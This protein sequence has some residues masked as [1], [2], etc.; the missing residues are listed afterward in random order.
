MCIRDRYW[1]SHVSV[2]P[3]HYDSIY[4]AGR[5]LESLEEAQKP[6]YLQELLKIESDYHGS[7]AAQLAN[8]HFRQEKPNLVEW[9]KIVR[10]SRTRQDTRAFRGWGFDE[11][12]AQGW[13]DTVRGNKEATD[14]LKRQV[15]IVVRDL[16]LH[17]PS[18]AASLALL[19][20]PVEKPMPPT[21]RLLAFQAVTTTVGNSTTDW[22][23]LMPYVQSGLARE[24]YMA[25][26]SLASGMLANITSVDEGRRKSGRN[27]V[28]QSYSRVGA[29]GLTIDEDS[30]LAPLLQAALSLRLGD[31]EMALETYNANKAL[32]D[33]HPTRCRPTWCYLS[34]NVISPR[35]ATRTT[36]GSRTSCGAGW[37]STARASSSTTRPRPRSSCC[38]PATSP[39]LNATTWLAVNSPLSRTVMLKRHRRSRPSSASVRRSWRRRSTTRQNWFSRSSPTAA[40]STS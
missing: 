30:P 38:W 16:R 35:G 31:Q 37:S 36:T 10:A 15:Y 19:E 2:D 11:G 14:A 6:A 18:A 9:E 3:N 26:A 13:V 27:V 21:T 20:L 40:N 5:V 22:D 12:L 24:D 28:A 34:V 25:A 33:Q 1:R 39:S 32:F 4:C 29:V 17:R 8:W 7:F 23:R